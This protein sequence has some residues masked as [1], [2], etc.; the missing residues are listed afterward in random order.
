MTQ[1]AA[2]L[3]PAEDGGAVQRLHVSVSSPNDDDVEPNLM[4]DNSWSKPHGRSLYVPATPSPAPIPRAPSPRVPPPPAPCPLGAGPHPI[5]SI[6]PIHVAPPPPPFASSP[7]CVFRGA[8]Y[9]GSSL[10]FCPP[11]PC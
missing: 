4:V 10:L 11:L 9:G 3:L 1:S 7:F 6:L 8:A 5:L 2:A